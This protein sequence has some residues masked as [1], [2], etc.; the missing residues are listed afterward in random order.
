MVQ[1]GEIKLLDGGV[2]GQAQFRREAIGVPGGKPGIEQAGDQG[3]HRAQSHEQAL[4]TMMPM[5]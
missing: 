1:V 4:R 3:Q 2:L 5:S